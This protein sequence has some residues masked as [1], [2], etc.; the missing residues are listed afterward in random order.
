MTLGRQRVTF[1]SPSAAMTA[2]IAY[3]PEDR[4]QEGLVLD[5]S[6]AQNVTL[7]ILPRLFPRFLV[8]GATERAVADDYTEQFNV[9]MTGVEQMV[10]ALSGG[11][12]QKVVLAKWLA[13][14]PRL[15]ILDEPTRGI[16][17]GAK[18]E[19]HRIISE[20]AAS[21]LGIILISSDLPEVIAMSDRILV[22]H[23]GRVTAEIAARRATEERVMFAATGNLSDETDDA[24][25]ARRPPMSETGATATLGCPR[26]RGAWLGVIARQRELSLVAIMVVLGALVS[27][28][29]PQ[30][31]TVDNISQVAVLASIVA[32]AAV[33]EALVVI[34]RNVDLS[35]E[36]MMGL[37]AY[38]VASSLEQQLFGA[39]GAILFGIGI[40]LLLGMVNG[41]IVTVLR[42]PAIV[43]TLGTLS[44][45]RGID[46]LIAG[47]H[48]VPLAGLPP[49]FTDA[50]HDDILG[51]PIFVVVAVVV[52][53]IGSVA[54]P[55][56][57]LRPPAL[58]GRQQSRGRR[59]P[60]HPVTARRLRGLL[61]VR[62]AGRHRRGH[63]RHRV[64]DDQR[65]VGAGGY[66][67]QVIAAVV[68]GGVGIFGGTGTLAGAALGALFL[69]FI[70]NALILI[71]L[72]QF[73]LQAIYGLVIL[74]AVS[75]DAV[76][77]RR[78]QRA[79]SLNRSR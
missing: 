53:V 4:H 49:G 73:W 64:R 7:P 72:S 40:G 11:N 39:P 65:D 50:A 21:G 74:V 24:A 70:A 45:F 32:V 41:F 28:A 26:D 1:A 9:K 59:D 17:I 2:G 51:I 63:V 15:L 8:N 27:I 22:L 61:A 18:V 37:V 75:A 3:L 38:C 29:A 12:Q 5:F 48:Q 36:A 67:L 57:P 10:G 30:F 14:K 6:I 69:G 76:I 13:S 54:P 23:E 33:G 16:D 60:R 44:I 52:V 78:L 56:D 55:L 47:S 34:T 19:V 43:A 62:V 46:Y 25:R 35:V 77:L 20:L 66:T 68:V 71:G 42:V 58:R 79:A 31:L